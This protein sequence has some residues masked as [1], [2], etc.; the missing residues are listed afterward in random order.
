MWCIVGLGNPGPRYRWS[1]HNVGFRVVDRICDEA[2]FA[3]SHKGREVWW[4]EG[5]WCGQRVKV[6]QPRTYMNLSGWAVLALRRTGCE[7]GDLVVVHDD[8]D[9]PLGKLKFKWRGGDAGHRGI[10][11]ILEALGQ[12]RFLRLRIGIGRPPVG[13]DPVDFVLESFQEQEEELVEQVLDRALE[14]LEVLIR[15]GPEEAMRVCHAPFPSQERRTKGST[16]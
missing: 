4:G 1:R 11:S 9:L 16:A 5:D 3:L 12:D 14:G 2:G 8:M 7:P 6:A 15:E 10:R 13:V